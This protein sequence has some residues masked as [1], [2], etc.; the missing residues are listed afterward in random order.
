MHQIYV[1]RVRRHATVL[2]DVEQQ[3]HVSGPHVRH[4]RMQ[5]G[6]IT[7]IPGRFLLCYPS[8]TAQ[9]YSGNRGEANCR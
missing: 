5:V 3:E 9:Q 4:W 7:R 6:S 2:D 1:P 8:P